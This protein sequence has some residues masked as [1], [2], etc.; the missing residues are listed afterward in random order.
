[1]LTNE[2][3]LRH[4]ELERR[5]EEMNG[6]R[7][8]PPPCT[9]INAANPGNVEALIDDIECGGDFQYPNN[10]SQAAKYLRSFGFGQ[11]AIGN[12]LQDIP[13]EKRVN[14]A[15]LEAVRVQQQCAID[16]V[17]EKPSPSEKYEVKTLTFGNPPVP[18]P[19]KTTELKDET[20]KPDAGVVRSEVA[21]DEYEEVPFK[22]ASLAPAPQSPVTILPTAVSSSVVPAS[23]S[24]P[25]PPA[26][27]RKA[28]LPEDIVLVGNAHYPT[29]RSGTI[30]QS[31]LV[32]WVPEI[33][34]L[35]QYTA[36]DLF[37]ELDGEMVDLSFFVNREKSTCY[38][39]NKF[40]RSGNKCS[41]I[42]NVGVLGPLPVSPAKLSLR[43]ISINRH[44]V[45][46]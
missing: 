23:A 37:G 33:K 12:I 16:G 31:H 35:P 25:P 39:G 1:M 42:W 14:L 20:P 24:T 11:E 44:E 8:S 3:M 30:L 17:P 7:P 36:F 34:E 15:Y 45:N 22:P 28:K 29:D 6:M 40:K 10:Y 5:R 38:V 9:T 2:V 46:P 26:K 43:V 21:D 4:L 13:H 32:K 18:T 27:V 41:V 19:D